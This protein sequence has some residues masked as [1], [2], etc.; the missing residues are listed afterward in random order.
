[1]GIRMESLEP[2]VCVEII[3]EGNRLSRFD[4]DSLADRGVLGR[5]LNF[6]FVVASFVLSGNGCI[7]DS[8]GVDQYSCPWGSLDRNFTSATSR[9]LVIGGRAFFGGIEGGLG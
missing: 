7:A 2:F 3:S 6:N 1:M 5:Q 9:C 4:I 8:L